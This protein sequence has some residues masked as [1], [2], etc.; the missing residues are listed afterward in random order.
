MFRFALTAGVGISAVSCRTGVSAR[1]EF[2]QVKT[3]AA[4]L[5]GN[6]NKCGLLGLNRIDQH[7]TRDVK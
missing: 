5:M 2:G 3:L 6:Q 4:T 7:A 1:W